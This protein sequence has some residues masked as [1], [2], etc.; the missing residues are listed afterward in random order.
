MPAT[1]RWRITAAFGVFTFCWEIPNLLP[2][3]N[4]L[5]V[6]TTALMLDLLEADA[7]PDI[8]LYEPVCAMRKLS[9]HPHG[10]WK[11]EMADHSER[12][13]LDLLDEFLEAATSGADRS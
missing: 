6:G 4:A 9:H 8:A 5:K 12:S 2:F 3:A 13:A 7:L 1:S 11:V 10:P